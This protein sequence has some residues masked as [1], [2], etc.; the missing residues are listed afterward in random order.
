M[1]GLVKMDTGFQVRIVIFLALLVSLAVTVPGF[2]SV[3]NASSIIENVG[4]I[5]LVGAGIMLTMIVGQL[6]L[7]VASVAAVAAIIAL[8]LSGTSLVLGISVAIVAASLYGATV[9]YIINRTGVNSLVLTVCMLIGV[10]GLALVMTPDRPAILPFEMFWISDALVAQW[11]PLT[12]LGVI[13][14]VVIGLVGLALRHTKLGLSM[15]AVGGN[16]ERARGSGISTAR[17]YMV[18]FAG[19][20]ILGASAG[21]LAALRSGSA[22]GL[23]FESFL[24]AGITVAVVGG[25]PLEGGRGTVINVILG[26]LI[27]RLISSAVALGGIPGSFESV[28]VGGILLAMLLLD[29]WLAKRR[30]ARAKVPKAGLQHASTHSNGG[31]IR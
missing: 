30:Q 18:A 26:A 27:I 29:Y 4:L 1:N 23:G 31:G 2:L 22:S 10:R 11:G 6:D 15:Y 7:A 8:S 20:A 3:A 16:L 24:L 21:I 14:L 5:G 13:C 19:S 25:I 28:A 9:G 17:V 12:L